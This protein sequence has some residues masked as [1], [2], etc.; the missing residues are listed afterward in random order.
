MIPYISAVYRNDKIRNAVL[1]SD[2]IM[3]HVL[4]FF[5]APP[6]EVEQTTNKSVGTNWFF[7]KRNIIVV[8]FTKEPVDYAKKISIYLCFF[9]IGHYLLFYYIIAFDWLILFHY[10]FK[11]IILF[12]KNVVQ[13]SKCRWNP[14]FRFW[15]FLRV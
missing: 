10:L 14:I 13:Y 5:T 3:K 2:E 7:C 4:E 11:K 9:V 6:T 8:L 12:K 1:F 15:I